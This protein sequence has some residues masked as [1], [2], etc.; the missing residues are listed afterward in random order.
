MICDRFNSDRFNSDRLTV[1]QLYK[2]IIN[3]FRA[4]KVEIYVTIQTKS[5]SYH[6]VFCQVYF[7][8]RNN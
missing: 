1:L 4:N 2:L 3:V 6:T 5:V 8:L 7:Q